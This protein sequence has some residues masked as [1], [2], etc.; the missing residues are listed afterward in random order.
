MQTIAR[1]VDEILSSIQQY[2]QSFLRLKKS[3]DKIKI[4]KEIDVLISE[5]LRLKEEDIK[6]Y[7]DSKQNFYVMDDYEWR[8]TQRVLCDGRFLVESKFLI[9][10]EN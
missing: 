9:I 4:E 7:K 2:K 10:K 3:R 8:K 1:R 6:R 5:F